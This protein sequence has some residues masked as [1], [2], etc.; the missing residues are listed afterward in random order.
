MNTMITVAHQKRAEIGLIK[1]LGAVDSQVAWIFLAQG[2]MVGAFGVVVG[3]GLAELTL[4]F[5]NDLAAW[6]GQNFGVV[7][8]TD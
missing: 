8:F 1:A 4:F 2:M 5:R 7:F 6:L 3:L